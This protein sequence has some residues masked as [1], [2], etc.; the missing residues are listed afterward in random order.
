MSGCYW[1]S[2]D[3]ITEQLSSLTYLNPLKTFKK[4][5]MSQI[6]KKLDTTHK[7]SKLIFL[8]FPSD[9]NFWA[10]HDWKI[11]TRLRTHFYGSWWITLKREIFRIF[12]NFPNLIQNIIQQNIN[13][14]WR[15]FPM[16]RSNR[17][18]AQKLHISQQS[19]EPFS[20]NLSTSASRK[21][22]TNSSLFQLAYFSRSD[23]HHVFSQQ[24][25]M[26]ILFQSKHLIT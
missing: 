18:S 20:V 25:I 2:W 23:Q 4:A 1:L 17:Y 3:Y 12:T 14:Q 19:F 24:H 15:F 22:T 10:S 13:K 21:C 7:N 11:K 26:R 16:N 5:L 8:W 6:L 9:S